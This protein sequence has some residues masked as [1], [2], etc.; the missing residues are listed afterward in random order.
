MT[1]DLPIVLGMMLSLLGLTAGICRWFALRLLA[2]FETRLQRVEIIEGKVEK[3]Y[4]ELPLAYHRREDAIREHSL[5]LAR[6]DATA[7]LLE[8]VVRRE[9]YLRDVSVLHAKMDALV[10]RID[11]ILEEKR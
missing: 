10:Q 11:R 8:T 4:S 6:I 2:D 7:R 5:V 9:D 3:L 1:I